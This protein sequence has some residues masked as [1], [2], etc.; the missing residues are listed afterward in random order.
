MSSTL[1]SFVGE[2]DRKCSPVSGD[3]VLEEAWYVHR[4]PGVHP[5]VILDDVT[6]QYVVDDPP[7]RVFPTDAHGLEEEE[8][9][10]GQVRVGIVAPSDVVDQVMAEDKA[11]EG[12]LPSRSLDSLFLQEGLNT[13]RRLEVL[14][15]GNP[16]D[17]EDPVQVAPRRQF[18]ASQRSEDD[19]A[20]V[21]GCEGGKGR[22][23]R[24]YAIGRSLGGGFDSLPFHAEFG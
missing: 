15:V 16:V 1:S 8:H 9:A 11:T 10:S 4:I 7:I 19:D 5:A 14:R 3:V 13:E 20:C 22:V 2:I 23:E 18:P 6:P 21:L 12:S 17:Q 24:T